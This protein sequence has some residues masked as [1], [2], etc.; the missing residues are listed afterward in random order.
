G[1]FGKA[2]PAAAAEAHRKAIRDAVLEKN[3]IWFND[4]QMLNGVHAYGRRYKPFGNVNYPEEIEKLRQMTAI[5]DE[6]IWAAAKGKAAPDVAAE[7]AHTRPLSPVETN[8]KQ[9]INY[10]KEAE[11]LSKFTMAD[12]YKIELFASEEQFPE[13]RNPVQMSFDNQ[14]RLWVS[15]LPGYP[16][17]TPGG[18]RPNDK[19]LIFEDTDHDGR[20]DDMKV[21]A[22]GLNLP[23]GFEIAPEGVYVS[24]EPNLCRL[25]DEDHDDKADRLEILMHGFDSHDTHHA[26][27]A[28]CADASGAFYMC[29]GRFLHSQVETP[30]GPERVNDGGV[31]R[32]DPNSWRLERFSQS[33]YNNPWGIAFDEWGQN[34][35]SD[36]SSGQNWWALPL[37]AKMP[38]GI[39][40]DKEDEFAP[41]RA[42]PTS[43]TE[44]IYSRH[45][46]DEVQG[47]FLINNSIGF[48]GTTMFDVWEDGSGFSGKVRMDLLQSSDP[49]FRPVDCEIAPDGSLY[50]VD[51][52]NALI[53]HMQHSARDPNRDVDHG[54]IYRVTYPSRPLV[55][56]PKIAGQPVAALLDNLKLPEYRARYR[57]RR[58]LRAH[59]AAEVIPAV[60]AWAAKLDKADPDYE[61]HLLEAL[62][63]TWAQNQT[64]PDL[65]K[66][67]LAASKP[68]CR[69]GAVR[70]LRYAYRK[71]PGS[72][73][74]FLAAA[75]D[76][77]P[78]VRLEAIV[79]ASW[80]DNADGARII[81]EGLKKP[82]DKWMGK[83]VAAAMTTLKDDV[84]A[85]VATGK[86]VLA[87]NPEVEKFLSGTAIA[88]AEQA[89][90]IPDHLKGADRDRYVLGKEVY[91]RDAHCATCHQPDAKG[92]PNI[93]PPLFE[94]EWVT[95]DEDRLIKIVL[96]GLW[97]PIEVKG[98]VFD[99]KNGVPPMMGFAGLLDDEEIAGVLT[100]IRNSFGNQ[101]SPIQPEA[102]KRVREATKDRANFYMVEEILK[103]HPFKK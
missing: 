94:S 30:Y 59:P 78:R 84:A 63:A 75:G 79:A 102:V 92:L 18:A 97:G 6:A 1:L 21:F 66:Q 67:C 47:D 3:W 33:D 81:A 28:Y 58:E 39:E 98:Q 93:Y 61:R 83:A 41:K 11:A 20:A 103:E 96:K 43:G 49:N 36:A 29:E 65:L 77:H 35:I 34:Y 22:D 74:L 14:G 80:L 15:V 68:Q 87:E 10:L 85:L 54:R 50:I 64:D 24:Q 23:I 45:F 8:F 31:W 89:P 4:Y 88:A 100:Y 19:I 91:G 70:V 40:I 51:W 86:M 73:D 53:G 48:L 95:G 9:P 76:E 17:Y 2:M 57:T 101:A 13:L 90:Q 72:T 32:F 12:G 69:A 38:Y 25:V 46:P 37:S 60:K 26:I 62:W 55:A 16:H 27:S 44:F 52:H 99:P 71:I 5:R 56:A 7:D 42:R 82:L